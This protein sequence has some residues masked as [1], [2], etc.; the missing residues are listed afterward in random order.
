MS[1]LKLRIAFILACVLLMALAVPVL[2][3]DYNPGVSV[4]QWVEYG[5]FVL[6]D[7]EPEIN[8]TRVEVIAVSGKEVTLNQW[9]EYMNG[10]EETVEKIYNVETGTVDGEPAYF[11]GSYVIA[12]NL[13]EGD[14]LPPVDLGYIVN[15][16][17]T[18]TYLGSSRSVNIVSY[19]Y[20]A[21]GYTISE[22]FVYDEAS[23]MQLVY[24]GETVVA[25]V[26]QTYSQS[27]I[28]TNI[29]EEAT[30]TPEPT[31]GIPVEYIYVAVIV[32]AIVIVVIAI[33]LLKKK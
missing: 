17:E 4:G 11:P 19:T 3:V 28:D 32:V 29:F 13:N 10:T 5:N 20:A 18:R 25:E 2:A 7:Q 9:T 6:D 26:T 15:T 8:R 1:G 21:E 27:I 22:S 16:T 31:E 33:V 30:P 14:A 24:E 23:G 12:A